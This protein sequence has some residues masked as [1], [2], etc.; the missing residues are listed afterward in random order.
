[1]KKTFLLVGFMTLIL[2]ACASTEKNPTI[3]QQLKSKCEMN[4]YN[5]CNDL[6]YLNEYGMSLAVNK[7]AAFDL[8]Q[9]SCNGNSAQGCNNLGRYYAFG[10]N[11]IVEI[12]TNKAIE[13]FD[14]ACQLG[15]KPAC[16]N[17]NIL[18]LQNSVKK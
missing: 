7:Q 11:D 2:S 6:G 10:T 4:D 18:L 14:K 1:M 8:Y 15:E 9:K 16:S 12:D 5:A 17:L 13:L 3:A